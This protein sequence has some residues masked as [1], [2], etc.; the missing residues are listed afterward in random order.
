MIVNE[1]SLSEIACPRLLTRAPGWILQ[2][3]IVRNRSSGRWK[4]LVRA[5]DIELIVPQIELNEF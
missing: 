4:T 1:A 2:K 3:T 5:R